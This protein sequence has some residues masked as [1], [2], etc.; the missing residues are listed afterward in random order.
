MNE[1]VYPLNTIEKE[2]AMRKILKYAASKDIYGLGR[3]GEYNH[4]NSD[5][6]VSNALEMG[7]IL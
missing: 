3:W 5:V 1:Y 6:V 4:Y 2:G 7:T